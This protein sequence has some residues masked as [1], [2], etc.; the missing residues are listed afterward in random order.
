MVADDFEFNWDAPF[1]LK[2]KY[3]LGVI[4]IRLL[5][6][7]VVNGKVIITQIN[8]HSKQ[9]FKFGGTEDEIFTEEEY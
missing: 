3:P 9:T 4:K 5:N 6:S 2:R 1:T 8:A 7:K